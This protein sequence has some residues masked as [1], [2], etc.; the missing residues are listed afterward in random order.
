MYNTF[1]ELSAK[2]QLY[3]IFFPG[4]FINLFYYNSIIVPDVEEQ[5]NIHNYFQEKPNSLLQLVEHFFVLKFIMG[6]IDIRGGW[7]FLQSIIYS[8][9]SASSTIRCNTL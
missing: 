6:Q 8:C 5:S 3:M 7:F 9:F 2:F 4:S 1:P